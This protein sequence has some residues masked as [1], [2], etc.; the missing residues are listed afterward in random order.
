MVLQ[1][2]RVELLSPG[3]LLEPDGA[4]K[5]F[6][7]Q[8]FWQIPAH[9]PD[10]TMEEDDLAAVL[11]E[12]L[13]PHLTSDVPLAVSL[14]GGV[15]SS[16]VANLASEPHPHLHL[17]FRGGRAQRGAYREADRRRH[18][19]SAPRGDADGRMLRGEP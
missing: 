5:E 1:V 18:W 9:A 16:V 6:C 14:S 3:R 17:G 12:G 10:R 4:G 19:D 11:Q 7:Q 15:D 13:R 2:A 8:D